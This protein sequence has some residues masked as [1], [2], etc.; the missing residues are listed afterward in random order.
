MCHNGNVYAIE[1]RHM[2]F[3]PPH[4]RGTLCTQNA[5]QAGEFEARLMQIRGERDS[6]TE[7]RYDLYLCLGGTLLRNDP[8]TPSRFA[9]RRKSRDHVTVRRTR[10][11]LE[12]W[13]PCPRV[14][15]PTY[16]CQLLTLSH[17]LAILVLP[18]A[19]C[20]SRRTPAGVWD[21]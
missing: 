7:P 1:M 9:V 3:H 5:A 14:L 13:A 19:W 8:I 10:S 16:C 18:K 21:G 20:A 2:D 4:I 17:T 12:V 15:C 11:L 6:G